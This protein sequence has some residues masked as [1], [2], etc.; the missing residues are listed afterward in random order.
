LPGFSLLFCTGK[1]QAQKI[2]REM[3]LPA[4]FLSD[5]KEYVLSNKTGRHYRKLFAFFIRIE[6]QIFLEKFRKSFVAP[7]LFP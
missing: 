1:I 3:I 7:L 4:D 5:M 2:G 6:I